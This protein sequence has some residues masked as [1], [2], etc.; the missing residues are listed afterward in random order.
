MGI[1][2]E[3]SFPRGGAPFKKSINHD[4]TKFT[5][6]KEL[7][8]TSKT[9]EGAQ[10]N[11]NKKKLKKAKEGEDSL[12]VKSVEP[13][14]YDK[15][16]SGLKTLARISE[17]KGLELKLSLPGR[18]VAHVP[19]TKISQPYTEALRKV[20]EGSSEDDIEIK[21]LDDMYQ[22][23][24]LVICSIVEV[25][26]DNDFHRVT[27]TLYPNQVNDHAFD[28]GHVVMAA[29]KSVEDHGYEMD[30]GKS[31]RRAFLSH[32]KKSQKLSVGQ[33]VPCCV[34]KVEKNSVVLNAT[35]LGNVW[36]ECK[37][38]TVH[39]MFPGM[40]VQSKVASKLKNGTEVAFGDFKA[41]CH[42]SFQSDN[43]IEVGQDVTATILYVLPT[44]N[45]IYISLQNNLDFGKSNEASKSHSVGDL[46]KD[47]DVVE[48]DNRGLILNMLDS[49]TGVVPFR[50]LNDELKPGSKTAVSAKY[51][52][53]KV[54]VRVL[55]FDLFE[56][57][58]VCSMRKSN[59][60]NALVRL[61]SLVPGATLTGCKIK[62]F[63][64]KG[65]VVEVAKN[66]DGFIPFLHLS[67]VPLKH[68]ERKFSV[69]DK[70]K[71][72][73]L[74][75][76]PSKR[77]L[78]LTSKKLLVEQDY[79]IVD[80][81]DSH[82]IGK[83]TEGVV[84]QATHEGVLLQL[85]GETCGWVPK[86]RIS[87]EQ[88][89]YP[90]KLFFMGQVLKCKVLEVDE[91]KRKMILTL[92][93]TEEKLK[94]LGSKQKKAIDGIKKGQIYEDIKVCDVTSEGLAVEVGNGIKALIPKNHLTDN[95]GM[96]DVLLQSYQV[97]DSI[98]KA[99]CFERDVLPI[100]TMKSSILAFESSQITFDDIHE[101]QIIPTVVSNV[102]S[103]GVFVKLPIW[104]VPKSALIPLRMLSDT[105]IDDPTDF[106]A[107]HQT[108]IAKV[109]EKHSKDQKLTMTSK[110]SSTNHDESPR[111]F[112]LFRDMD[113]VQA[114]N[115]P[116]YQ[117]GDVVNCKVQEVTEFG[118]D[119][120]IEDE[121]Q[122]RGLCPMAGLQGL[123]AP[124]KG[125]TVAGVVI[126]VDSQFGVVELSIQPDIIKK[127]LLRAKKLP[128]NGLA[129]KA[130]CVLKRSC[131]D[132]ATFCV[133]SPNQFRGHFVHCPM[134]SEEQFELHR[135]FDLQVVG[136]SEH[137][138]IG[139]EVASKKRKRSSSFSLSEAPKNEPEAEQP[140][141]V[142]SKKAKKATDAEIPPE[143]REEDPGWS[144]D[145]NPWGTD[146]LVPKI[147]TEPS[148]SPSTLPE[149]KEKVK[150]HLSK[151]EK[152]ELEKLEELAIHRA[153][154]RVIEGDISPPAYYCQI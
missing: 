6:T 148:E 115:G 60:E 120:L 116:N 91:A 41:F 21:T 98:P 132:M 39:Q 57:I 131:L 25:D 9:Q 18:L 28:K 149:A 136:S 24:Q 129:V 144:E 93:L 26:S 19:I 102:K 44:V 138:L 2:K 147:S 96:A 5:K 73:V 112:S 95:I 54:Q 84:V 103:Y 32:K 23:G 122:T 49:A 152:K 90:E 150:T 83:V 101:G 11:K 40:R 128:K 29:V 142:G 141:P 123:E 130:V 67:D 88:I 37:D 137:R 75:V 134:Q 89:E 145:F 127:T 79:P 52:K 107:P 81:F 100:L 53:T 16:S 126:F 104:K 38:L 34:T 22:I 17:I 14:T 56:E 118:L 69:G 125:Q 140:S 50:H 10:R 121:Q 82:H 119:T 70:L 43:G 45:H 65:V 51:L 20:T 72:R 77:R 109:V 48:I 117:V 42:V 15:L 85:F 35:K 143:V 71:C 4:N 80:D 76:D 46:V 59:I 12:K 99:L 30:V 106:A 74:K 62:K 27:A 151:K 105:F 63:A 36:D 68:P 133:K 154:K 66:L 111:L 55:Q 97:G 1:S 153:E 3:K 87:V 13:L 78:H 110:M 58:F 33:V 146:I 7:F 61:D 64:P 8:S 114:K 86:S 92:I 31:N 113:R 124:I 47:C 94:P 108:L 139:V 135:T